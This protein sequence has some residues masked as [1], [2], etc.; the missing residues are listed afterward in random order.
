MHKHLALCCAARIQEDQQDTGSCWPFLPTPICSQHPFDSQ[1]QVNFGCHTPIYLEAFESWCRHCCT[2][3]RGSA[4]HPKEHTDVDI[5]HPTD[6]DKLTSSSILFDWTCRKTQAV[7]LCDMN[8]T[9]TGSLSLQ[10]KLELVTM[11]AV[12]SIPTT[13]KDLKQ[14]LMLKNTGP[15]GCQSWYQEWCTVQASD[16]VISKSEQDILYGCPHCLV[17][18]T[19]QNAHNSPTNTLIHSFIF[20]ISPVWCTNNWAAVQPGKS[21]P[22]KQIREGGM[23]YLTSRMLTADSP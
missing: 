21:Y 7:P 13:E 4:A 22:N 10:R 17:W 15:F 3:K 18:N 9:F 19:T 11:A 5:A 20:P 6:T 8:S 16:L 23:W 14:E 1:L 12:L 2:Q